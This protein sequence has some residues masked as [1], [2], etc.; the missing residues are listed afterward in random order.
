MAV[1]YRIVSETTDLGAEV[2]LPPRSPEPKTETNRSRPIFI[3]EFSVEPTQEARRNVR[4]EE[5]RSGRSMSENRA[6][7]CL[8]PS[9]RRLGRLHY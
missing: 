6:H 3:A 9:V 2:D 5:R 8:A 1:S 7:S 4:F